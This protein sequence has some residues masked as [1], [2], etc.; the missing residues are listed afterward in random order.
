MDEGRLL[1][2]RL[3][4]IDAIDNVTDHY[5]YKNGLINHLVTDGRWGLVFS[6]IVLDVV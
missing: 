6:N 3:L 5:N 2:T 1:C 4:E